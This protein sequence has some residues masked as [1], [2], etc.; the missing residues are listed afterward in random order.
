LD[1]PTEIPFPAGPLQTRT[2]KIRIFGPVSVQ[3]N[4]QKRH[5]HVVDTVKSGILEG[6]NAVL[7]PEPERPVMMNIFFSFTIDYASLKLSA[8]TEIGAPIPESGMF[9][10]LGVSA[11]TVKSLHLLLDD[12]DIWLPGQRRSAAAL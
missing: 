1:R 2:R 12:G 9:K 10:H 5:R 7:L 6:V 11:W 3:E 4:W 8:T